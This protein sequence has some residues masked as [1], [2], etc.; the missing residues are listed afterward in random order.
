MLPL[1]VALDSRFQFRG[2]H[3]L[4]V[5]GAYVA[6]EEGHVAVRLAL[7]LVVASHVISVE[8]VAAR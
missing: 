8:A 1:H 6:D 2:L 4:G 7:R 5:A 3:A